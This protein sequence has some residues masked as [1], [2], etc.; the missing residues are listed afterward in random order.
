MPSEPTGP[1]TASCYCG[2]SKLSLPRPPH[3]VAYCHC[4]DC[5]KWTGGPVGAFAAFDRADVIDQLGA[6]YKKI[7]SVERWNCPTCGTPLGAAFAYLPKQIYVPV[8]IL[9]Q[10]HLFPPQSH[11]Y[12][13]DQFPWLE[14]SDDLP[15]AHT[16]GRDGLNAAAQ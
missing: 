8:G 13:R 7:A 5:K 11:S 10:A 9:D 4:S 16:T 15:R 14:L 6:S 3:T 12:A 1:F 2:A